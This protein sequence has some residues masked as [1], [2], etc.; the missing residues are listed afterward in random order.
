MTGSTP[1][2]PRQ[3]GQT[4]EFGAALKA[5]AS[6]PQNILLRVISCAWISRPMIVSKSVA[7][8]TVAATTGPSFVRL[9][10]HADDEIALMSA[11]HHGKAASTTARGLLSLRA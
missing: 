5:A 11:Y 2:I 1:G 6:Q 4:C 7:G 8:V 3:T 10:A 9:P